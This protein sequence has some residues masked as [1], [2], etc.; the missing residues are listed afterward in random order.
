MKIDGVEYRNC[1]IEV[2]NARSKYY[3]MEHIDAL[4]NKHM[5]DRKLERQEEKAKKD[6]K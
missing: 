5:A 1:V 3:I 2:L 6:N 4:Y